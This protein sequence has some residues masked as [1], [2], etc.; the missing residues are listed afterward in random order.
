MFCGAGILLGILLLIGGVIL[1]GPRQRR[2][3]IVAVGILL[4][5]LAGGVTAADIIIPDPCYTAWCVPEHCPF[6]PCWLFWCPC[7]EIEQ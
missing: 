6:A 1:A 5:F 2:R 3:W 7:K 4:V